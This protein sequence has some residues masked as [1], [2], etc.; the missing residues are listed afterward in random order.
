MRILLINPPNCG[1]SI[2]EERYGIT[3]LKQIFRG[4]PLGLEELAG[5]LGEHEVRLLDLKVEPDG[6]AA[7]LDQFEPELVGLTGV[8]CEANTMLALAASIKQAGPTKVVVG[9]I[10]ASLDPEFFNQAVIDYIVIGLGK[11]SFAQ[12]VHA[13]EQKTKTAP[14]AGVLRTTPGRPLAWTRQRSR[15]DDLVGDRP[16]A[17]H[18]T[19]G[20]RERYVLER[21][22]IGLGFVASA[23]GCPHGCSFCAIRAQTGGAYLT[24]PAEEVLRDISLLPETTVIRLVDANT[25]GDVE[26]ARNLAEAMLAAGVNRHFLADVRSDTVVRHPDLLRLWRQ[27]GLRAVIIGFE[28]IDDRS[29]QT[30]AKANS[31]RANTEAIAILHDLGIRVVGDFILNPE[32]E[33]GDFA[34]LGRYLGEHPIDLPMITV[35]TPLPGTPLHAQW[36]DRINNHDLDYYTLTNAVVPTRLPE[37]DFYQ[38]YA[39]LLAAGHRDARL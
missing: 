28:A 11:R 22:G 14:P 10:H 31:V 35:M 26:R 30:M 1:R 16:P 6:L 21:L 2:P 37:H 27:A 13:I 34:A 12:L 33:E 15:Q 18:L 5:N 32:A 9:G 29:L 4:E 8:T 19:A 20:Y 38:A 3:S 23:F 36:R 24:R 7:T 25:F 39:D 17:Y